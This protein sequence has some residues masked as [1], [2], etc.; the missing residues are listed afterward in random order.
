MVVSYKANITIQ[1]NTNIRIQSYCHISVHEPRCMNLIN[2]K[3]HSEVNNTPE[4]SGLHLIVKTMILRLS[5]G[6]CL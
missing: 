3:P 6:L 4:W 5:P 2:V 1:L